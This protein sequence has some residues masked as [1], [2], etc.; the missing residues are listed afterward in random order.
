[1]VG[2]PGPSAVDGRLRRALIGLTATASATG[3]QAALD[4]GLDQAA[5]RGVT[6][7]TADLADPRAAALIGA[8]FDAALAST[9]SAGLP[10]STLAAALGALDLVSTDAQGVTGLSGDGFAALRADP[11]GYL[12]ARIP[13]ALARPDGWAGLVTDLSFTP[14]STQELAYVWAPPGSPYALFVRRQTDGTWRAG[15]ETGTALGAVEP[16][17]IN[18]SADIDLL[19]P[20]FQATAE[21]VL[22]LGPVA[23]TYRTV[24]GTIRLDAAPFVTDLTLLP[25]PALGDLAAK[26][27]DALPQVL[28]SGVLGTVL[29]EL[30]P[31][32]K[33]GQLLE[34]L[35]TPGDFLAAALGALEGGLDPG[36]LTGLLTTLNS[37]IGLPTGPGLQLPADVT[38]TAVPGAA[39]QSVR[40]QVGTTSPI[41]D[42]LAVA[43]TL[44]ID[45]TRHVVPGGTVT[46][47]TPLTG[48]WPRVDI[49]FGV[50]P[51]G[52]TLVVSPQGVAPIALLPTFSGL[53]ALRGAAG[54]LLPAVLDAALTHFPEPRDDWLVHTLQA[55][56][57]L[58]V[59]DAAGHFSAHTAA[60]TAMLDGSW[61]T[62]IDATRRAGIAAAVADLLNLIPGLSL[63]SANGL[64]RWTH[65]VPGSGQLQVSAGWGDN[66]PTV[67]VALI[68]LVP[69]DAPLTLAAR[70][71]V[72]DTGVDVGCSAG[73]D[74]GALG[75]T[76]VPRLVIDIASGPPLS[77]RVRFLPLSSGSLDGPLAIELAPALAVTTGPAAAETILVDAAL[78]LVVRVAVTA[79]HD[80]LGRTLWTD[81][82]TLEAALTDAGI[83]AA[84]NVVET[85]P[86]VFAMLAGFV[87]GAAGKL[88]LPIGDL[89]VNLVSQSG[90]IGLGLS[91]QQAVPLGDLELQILFGAP[92]AWGTVAAEGLQILLLDT[93]GADPAFDFGLLL[94]GVGIGLDKSDGS[95]LVAESFLRLGSVRALLFLDLETAGGFQIL[96]GGAGLEL[97]G[98][99]LPIGA[100]LDAGGGS[101]PVAS[102]LLSSGG[103]SGDNQSVNPSADLDIWYWDHPANTGGP[104]RV[105]V[106]GQAGIFWIPIHAGFGPIFI[107]EIG[108]GVTSTAVSLAIDGGVSIA[109]LSAEV[110]DLTVTIPYAHVT[111]PTQWSLDLKGLAIGYS[112]PLVSIAGG[113]VKFDGPPV[114][115]DGMLLIKIGTIG[116]VVIGSYS[117]VGSGADEYTSFAI[118]GGVFVP[119]GLTPLINLTGIAV[120]LGY[121]RRLIVPE[122]LNQIPNFMLVKALDRPESLANNPMQ[123]LFEF[124]QQTPPARGALWLAAG[125][126]G[127]SFELV[128]ITAVLYVALDAGVD[129]GL[130]GVARMALP[131]DDAAIVSIEL[132]L[133]A[134]FSTA[135]GLFSV[136][137]QLTD[138]S[139]LITRDCQLTGGFAFFMW[140]RKSQF[141]LTVGGYH[142]SFKPLPEYPVVPRVGFRWDF[143]GVVHI[144]GESYFALT[145]TAVMTGT[146]MEA[147][148]GP[149]WIQVWF[150]AYTDI[151]IS[152]DPF[153]YIV[154]VGISVGAR[155][156]IRICFF[157][158]CTIEISVSVGASLH[159][160]GP[161]FHGTVTA[162]LGVTSVTVP[163]GDDAQP[164]PPAKHWNEFVD[165]YVRSG[166]PNSASVSAQVST[167]L[168]PPEPPGGPVAPGTAEQPWRLAAEWSLR[169]ETRM[170]ARG[171]A[172]QLDIDVAESQIPTVVF[173]RYAD[174][175]ATYDF[176]LAPMYKTSDKITALH[177][178]VLA[179]KPE[180]ASTF[181]DLVPRSQNPADESLEIDERLFRVQAIVGQFSEA[182]YHFFPDLKPPAAS[183]TL[184]ALTGIVLEGVAGLHNAS[185]TIPIGTLIDYGNFRPLP[186]ARRNPGEIAAVLRAGAAWLT[187]A[188]AAGGVGT[189][190]LLTGVG[191]IVGSVAAGGATEFA[192]LRKDS[193]LQ[194]GY[195]PVALN[196]LI[197]RRS[198]PPVLSALSE[199]FTLEDQGAG[200]APEPVRVGEVEPV[201]LDRPRLRAMVQRQAVVA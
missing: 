3:I 40:I 43:L 143:L 78:P 153:H 156:R 46:I 196:A 110:D 123:A 75:V 185:E 73:L 151:L 148:Y 128:N 63:Q 177:R 184:P 182:T 173:G 181:V 70:V 145:N 111:D 9:D 142:P 109:G 127:T 180:N 16:P 176:D 129:V 39:P 171:F 91:G 26:L 116:A 24:D 188:Q 62:T 71:Q 61:F 139:W 191:T 134:R 82:P 159:L 53:G 102:N 1:I 87:A 72:D 97:G 56:T 48:S 90:R 113:L 41:G 35:H 170:A 96:H 15:I 147:T 104:L 107:A 169:T 42:V 101:N 175:Q 65:L 36:K 190:T 22:H 112:G 85:L 136:Q 69:T 164:L 135:E 51:D 20:A 195:G 165:T 52:V 152:W 68:D 167:G 83:L 57:D 60:F 74:L 118:Y 199:G 108:L 114:E 162:D 186:F 37:A 149:D 187:L 132:A 55:A 31:G 47:S 89:H 95:A 100:A 197:T 144:K 32:L 77:L 80:V 30:V 120:G 106:G 172:L 98:F 198:A 58:G 54:A 19:L 76:V 79:L 4:A 2:G 13:G 193:G 194:N 122:D 38:V 7:P 141:L 131:T 67:A 44:D 66:G 34:L 126:R 124:R 103:S 117:V 168:L 179:K 84:G 146:R 119:I 161:P 86:N 105:L 125:V 81:G 6:V 21:L 5:W 45:P 160:E 25:V 11:V 10:V 88:D 133:K 174:L 50:G 189:G 154:D 140:F 178:I 121:N 94:H 64:V 150:T 49:T 17:L 138:N 166:D 23:L 192:E 29:A 115:Y 8:A 183:N 163:F 28:V 93:S 92:S 157:A 99:G 59:Y 137:A 14:A 155:L 130:I 33:I 200:V 18:I 158:C 201:L 27:D 12:R